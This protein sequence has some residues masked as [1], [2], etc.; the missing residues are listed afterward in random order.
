MSSLSFSACDL[1]SLWSRLG[2]DR[3]VPSFPHPGTTMLTPPTLIIID[4]G[5]LQ[6]GL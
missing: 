5:Y 2:R 4:T 3:T 1:R 6:P